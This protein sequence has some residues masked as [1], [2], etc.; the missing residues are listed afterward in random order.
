MLISIIIPCYNAEKWISDTLESVFSQN[1]DFKLEVIVI[2]DGSTN[3]S[4]NII[5]VN[6]PD[7]ILKTTKNLGA[8]QAR[9]LGIQI[10]TGEY[11]FFLDADDLIFSI[12]SINNLIM[13]INKDIDMIY[14]NVNLI[15]ND[16]NIEIE[17]LDKINDESQFFEYSESCYGTISMSFHGCILSMISGVP[18]I[19]ITNGA[20]YN[21][22]YI[23]F[24]RYTGYQEVPIIDLT[25]FNI[26][27]TA[28]RV[29][30]YFS[31]YNQNLTKEYRQR[32]S[33]QILD[34]YKKIF[35]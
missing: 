11:I 29:L 31:N 27:E 26:E 19:P 10:A 7:V 17:V 32:A 23:D 4:E 25:D 18:S 14:G 33:N 21:Y 5:K 13:N 6:Y 9:N 1:G 34:W 22:K 2:N 24:D 20:Y 30:N 16:N 3:N 8:S 35:I 12:E 28:D 15:D